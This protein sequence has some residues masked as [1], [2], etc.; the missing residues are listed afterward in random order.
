MLEWLKVVCRVVKE[1]EEAG[2]EVC[3]EI[4]ELSS[5]EARGGVGGR[6]YDRAARSPRKPEVYEKRLNWVYVV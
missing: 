4:L 2:E 3:S 6:I 1:E 5:A